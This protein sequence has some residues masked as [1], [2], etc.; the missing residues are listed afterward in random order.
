VHSDF[1]NALYIY[2]YTYAYIGNCTS[3]P[4]RKRR[5][6][7]RRRRRRKKE[8]ISLNRDERIHAQCMSSHVP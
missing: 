6:R 2:I 3:P 5:R 4:R 8:R 7:R 1:P